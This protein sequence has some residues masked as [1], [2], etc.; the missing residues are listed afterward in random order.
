M[1]LP[2]DDS[3]LLQGLSL[4]PLLWKFKEDVKNMVGTRAW[5]K[6]AAL[7]VCESRD[8]WEQRVTTS[9]SHRQNGPSAFL[10]HSVGIELQTLVFE[11]EGGNQQNPEG[12]GGFGTLIISAIDLILRSYLLLLLWFKDLISVSLSL[13]VSRFLTGLQSK[14]LCEPNAVLKYNCLGP[15]SLR[16]RWPCVLLCVHITGQCWGPSLIVSHFLFQ[17]RDSH[18]T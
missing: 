13:Q 3:D 18:W 6:R 7:Q 10:K 8:M 4:L 11:N 2:E 12:G 16:G 17:H 5:E 15:M 9:T 14:G 1:G